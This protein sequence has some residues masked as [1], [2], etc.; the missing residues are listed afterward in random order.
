MSDQSAYDDID[1]FIGEASPEAPAAE[2]IHVSVA[3]VTPPP[4][5]THRPQPTAPVVQAKSLDRDKIITLVAVAV[6]VMCVFCLMGMILFLAVGRSPSPGPG[7]D[8][9]PGPVPAREVAEQF[10]KAFTTFLVAVGD[11]SIDN[12][13]KLRQGKFQGID[14]LVAGDKKAWTEAQ[15][16]LVEAVGTLDNKYIPDE[17]TIENRRALAE[18]MEASGEGIKAAVE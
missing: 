18:Y 1:A 14:E 3:E 8:P 5:E 7:P 4:V 15:T 16:A 13:K 17:L 2:E 11:H 12:A 9:T 6:S 10:E